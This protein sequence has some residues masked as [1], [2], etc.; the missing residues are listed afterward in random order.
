MNKTNFFLSAYIMMVFLFFASV[1]Y[2]STNK[3][4]LNA[5]YSAFSGFNDYSFYND[6]SYARFLSIQTP[7]QNYKDPLMLDD[8]YS[9]FT[10]K[11][12]K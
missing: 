5:S 12:L 8:S 3:K 7:I 11:G 2:I 4:E 1:F 6:E 10:Y 9:G